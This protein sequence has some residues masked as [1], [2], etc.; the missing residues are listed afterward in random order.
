[1]PWPQ[2]RYP[3]D[4]LSQAAKRFF[5]KE[6][7]LTSGKVALIDDEDFERVTRF[8]WFAHKICGIW[9][10]ARW[11]RDEN[12]D[13]K[14]VGLHVFLIPDSVQVDHKN[15]NGLDNQKHNLR[16][17]TASQNSANRRKRSGVSSR[18]KGVS[19]INRQQSWRAS[20]GFMGSHV[21]LGNYDCEE[22]AAV[23]YNHAALAFF[24]EFARINSV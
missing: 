7:P 22:D 20:I 13:S 17:A 6:I 9:Y 12:G 18:Y 5:M 15:G 24:G 21:H 23:S 2:G 10:A 4:Q 14:Q 8:K 3:L 1:M 11:F 16:P 19:W